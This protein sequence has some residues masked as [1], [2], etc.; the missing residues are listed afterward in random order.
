MKKAFT[1]IEL[2]FVSIILGIL[3][4]V[5]M[6]KMNQGNFEDEKQKAIQKHQTDQSTTE[7]W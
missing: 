5:V 3:L 6:P 2:I 4:G 1:M 7:K